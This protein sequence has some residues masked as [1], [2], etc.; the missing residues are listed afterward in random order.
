MTRKGHFLSFIASLAR[1][2]TVCAKGVGKGTKAPIR[3]IMTEAYNKISQQWKFAQ[4][5]KKRALDSTS[6]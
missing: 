4:G 6:R 5:S 2:L 3:A 1:D